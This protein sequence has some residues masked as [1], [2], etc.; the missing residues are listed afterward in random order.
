[1]EVPKEIVDFVALF[2]GRAIPG[3]K[4]FYRQEKLPMFDG[5]TNPYQVQMTTVESIRIDIPT[6]R[7]KEFNDWVSDQAMFENWK[8]RKSN[9]AV[10]KAYDKYL[11]LIE[12]LRK[13]HD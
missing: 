13:Q 5:D 9:P 7:V 4:K 6:H 12:L 8:I 1:M 3:D 10:Q 2:E 11:M